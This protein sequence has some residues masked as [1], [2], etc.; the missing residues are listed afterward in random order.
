MNGLGGEW[1][2]VREAI[3]ASYWNRSWIIFRFIM[4]YFFGED[5][6]KSFVTNS[7]VS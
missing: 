1:G 4:A 5:E 7:K 3:A 2:E 6:K